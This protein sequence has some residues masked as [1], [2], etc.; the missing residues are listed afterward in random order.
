M[1]K[2]EDYLRL[3]GEPTS[4]LCKEAMD[5]Y[6]ALRARNKELED[7]FSFYNGEIPKGDKTLHCLACDSVLEVQ[8]CYWYCPSE[9]CE[10]SPI[11]AQK[12]PRHAPQGA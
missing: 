3:F 6:I 2:I 9:D 10:L 12:Q 4:G 7:Y 11:P 8:D 1:S 5:E